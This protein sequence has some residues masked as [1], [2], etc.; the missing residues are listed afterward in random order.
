MRLTG[1]QHGKTFGR[2]MRAD[3]RGSGV[4]VYSTAFGNSGVQGESS[5][6]LGVENLGLRDDMALP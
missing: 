1:R 6:F 5:G 3:Q 2:V 4:W